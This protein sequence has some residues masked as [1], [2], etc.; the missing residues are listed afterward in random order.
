MKSEFKIGLISDTHMP[1][2]LKTLWPGVFD[3]FSGCD[4]I[5][6]AGDLHTLILLMPSAKLRR[7]MSHSVMVMKA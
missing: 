5:L 7:P 3:F 6:H 2:A 4:A 1:G